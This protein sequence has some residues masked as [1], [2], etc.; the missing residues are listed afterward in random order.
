MSEAPTVTRSLVPKLVETLGAAQVDTSADRIERHTSDW[1]GL[2]PHAPEAVLRPKST[3]EVSEVLRLCHE[4]H[5]P[6]AVQ[7]GLTGL[8]GAA[9]CQDGEL[10]LSLDR[11]NAIELVGDGALI[12][13][14]GATV[15]AVQAAAREAGAEL[16]IDFGARGTATIGGAI[17]TN[18]GGLHVIETGMTRAQILGLEV[19]LAD[20]RVMSELTP[21]VKVN[22]GFDLKQL[23]IGAEGTLGVVTRA[24]LALR[25]WRPGLATALL[26]L[27]SPDL[28]P[29]ALSA[30]RRAF[31][32]DLS[33][34]E[35]MW[36]DYVD[37]MSARTPFSLPL[38]APMLL[39]VE[40]RDAQSDIASQR[41]EAF[42]EASAEA[43]WLSDAVVAQSEAQ[44]KALWALRDEGP[45]CYG[46]AFEEIL[47]FDVSVPLPALFDV[48]GRLGEPWQDPAHLYPLTYG[49]IGDQNLHF[50]VGSDRTLSDAER[51]AISKHVYAMV[52]AAKGAISAEHGIGMLKK[53]YLSQG[54]SP[55]AIDLM[56]D[57]K[58]T[59][60]PRGILNPGRVFDMD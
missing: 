28:T 15:G 26:A 37:T 8:A 32:P 10:A 55:V 43:G 51:E 29:T 16:G 49:H 39:I 54:R 18:A 9:A 33:A 7:G 36:P 50:V 44:A 19:V 58:R 38:S 48:A 42:L 35:A 6:V 27:P 5:Q 17:G 59:L 2:P 31:G 1:A 56:K 41:M 45:A 40:M 34:F 20:G 3:Q 13:G 52:V 46:S 12:A 30:A 21:M 23:F 57:M 60:D 47:A 11:L 25:P 14:A 53:P 24:C 4:H 22:T